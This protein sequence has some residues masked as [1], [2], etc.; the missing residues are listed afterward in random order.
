MKLCR[1]GAPGAEKP[2]LVDAEGR[3][4]DLSAHVADIDGAAIGPEGLAKLAGLDPASLP[5]VEGEVRYG[6]CVA[7]T[8]HFVA[9]GLNYADHADRKSTRLNSSHSCASRMPS[10]A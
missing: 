7:G 3:I 2:G 4:R 8:R 1:H 10:S 9:I 6:P 5:L